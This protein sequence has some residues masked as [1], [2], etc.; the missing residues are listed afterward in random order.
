M[1]RRAKSRARVDIVQFL[2]DVFRG[3]QKLSKQ[4]L[5]GVGAAHGFAS[6]TIRETLKAL[7]YQSK[8]KGHGMGATWFAVSPNRDWERDLPVFTDAQL[9]AFGDAQPQSKDMR[10][11]K[12]GLNKWDKNYFDDLD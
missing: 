3:R 12:N 7:G 6:R 8:R 11:P 10:A 4:N 9:E 5:F 2:K 1:L